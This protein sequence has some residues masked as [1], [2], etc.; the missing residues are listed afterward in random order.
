MQGALEHSQQWSRNEKFPIKG[1]NKGPGERANWSERI[2]LR[3]NGKEFC[4]ESYVELEDGE[5]GVFEA[6]KTAKFSLPRS[7]ISERLEDRAVCRYSERGGSFLL[8][9]GVWK[10]TWMNAGRS[11]IKEV[12]V[13]VTIMKEITWVI[14]RSPRQSKDLKAIYINGWC[15]TLPRFLDTWRGLKFYC[16]RI[17]PET[18]EKQNISGDEK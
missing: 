14:K 7:E 13:L 2:Q 10:I 3:V 18:W 9:G 17:Y 8:T 5:T 11:T 16:A 6:L 4:V 12:G 15:I 1:F